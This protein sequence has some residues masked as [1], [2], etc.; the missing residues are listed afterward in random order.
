MEGDWPSDAAVTLVLATYLF[1]RVRCANTSMGARAAVGSNGVGAWATL[2]GRSGV[3]LRGS[4]LD[5]ST[6]FGHTPAG[7]PERLCTA[8]VPFCGLRCGYWQQPGTLG[9]SQ[10]ELTS[11]RLKSGDGLG[12]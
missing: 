11:L 5:D 7:W 8:C 1:A 9:G 4:I 3:G 10:D 2:R 12:D 6:A